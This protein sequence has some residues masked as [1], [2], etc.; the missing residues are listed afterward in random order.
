MSVSSIAGDVT[1]SMSK[2]FTTDVS[3]DQPVREAPLSS[4]RS[5]SQAVQSS[6]V[7]ANPSKKV[8]PAS[9]QPS[10]LGL[11]S[12][13]KAVRAMNNVV[14]VYNLKGEARTKFMDSKNEVVYQIPSEMVAKI[15]DRMLNPDTSTSRKG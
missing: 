2:H 13:S 15:E 3:L 8:S 14:E 9:Q 5:P 4:D 10:D 1:T 7:E 12:Q 11:E 6:A